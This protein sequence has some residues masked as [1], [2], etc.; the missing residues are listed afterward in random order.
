[1]TQISLH[2]AFGLA[3]VDR[4]GGL[5]RYQGRPGDLQP[6]SPDGDWE[7]LAPLVQ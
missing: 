6:A 5:A 3:I 7:R 1:M 4:S 2:Y